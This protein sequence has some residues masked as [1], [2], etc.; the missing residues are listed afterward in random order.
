MRQFDRKQISL[1]SLW[2]QRIPAIFFE[3]VYL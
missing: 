2:E 3:S 1:E